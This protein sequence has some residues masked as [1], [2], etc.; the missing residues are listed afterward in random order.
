METCQNW[1]RGLKAL[2]LAIEQTKKDHT[3]ACLNLNTMAQVGIGQKLDNL[4]FAFALVTN[5]AVNGMHFKNEYEKAL[6][7][8]D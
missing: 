5:T 6:R 7:Y 1:Y 8:P 4:Q 3:H 2:A